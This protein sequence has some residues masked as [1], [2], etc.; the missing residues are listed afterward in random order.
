MKF[1]FIFL[2]LLM[3]CSHNWQ[4]KVEYSNEISEAN[5]Q[6]NAAILDT[7]ES[8][9]QEEE[10]TLSEE[11]DLIKVLSKEN[12][13][14]IGSPVKPIDVRNLISDNKQI[15]EKAY[16]YLEKSQGHNRE[17][18]GKLRLTERKLEILG[19]EKELENNKSVWAKLVASFGFFGAIATIVAACV[20]CPALIPVFGMILKGIIGAIPSVISFFGVVGSG[21]VRNIVAGISSIKEK[22]KSEP[23]DKT[24]TKEEVLKLINDELEK[25]TDVQDKKIIDHLKA[26]Q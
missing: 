18:L 3:G 17:L 20:L 4:D 10:G 19:R 23:D 5:R 16:K 15:R 2:F 25:K 26:S 24:Y 8:I 12:E 22:I 13:A 9:P 7:V 1:V 14:L 11:I 6:N 21:L